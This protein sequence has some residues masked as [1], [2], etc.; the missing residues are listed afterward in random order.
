MQDLLRKQ[1]LFLS[2]RQGRL[3]ATD[4][5]EERLGIIQRDSTVSARFITL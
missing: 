2:D 1:S 5:S 4:L 3:S